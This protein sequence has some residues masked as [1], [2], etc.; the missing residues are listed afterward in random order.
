MIVC[1][2][3]LI[4]AAIDSVTSDIASIDRYLPSAHLQLLRDVRDREDLGDRPAACR[5]AAAGTRRVCRDTTLSVPTARPFETSGTIRADSKPAL[6]RTLTSRKSAS[7]SLVSLMRSGSRDR[8]T[9]PMAVR[10]ILNTISGRGRVRRSSSW[11]RAVKVWNSWPFS[12][13]SASPTPIA[14][15]Q[16]D[17]A[18]GQRLER[19]RHVDRARDDLQHR[20]LR[21]ELADPIQRLRLRVLVLGH[22]A[23]EAADPPRGD[24]RQHQDD[25]PRGDGLQ[26][27][28]RPLWDAAAIAH[29]APS[30][31][32]NAAT[33]DQ[34][35]QT[36][37]RGC[38]R[39]IVEITL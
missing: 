37:T 35:A 26:H 2:A 23:G 6:C 13:S 11:T 29:E 3:L 39:F 25:E 15:H 14:G 12:V 24:R 4:S 16:P 18:L 7:A 34:M 21:L 33:R 10:S 38:R 22:R 28:H 8:T 27:G 17:D 19:E 5:C 36:A 31:T 32:A 30:T 1:S 9:L 20:V